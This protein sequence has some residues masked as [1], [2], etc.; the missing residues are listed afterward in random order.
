MTLAEDVLD[1]YELIFE[2]AGYSVI[3]NKAGVDQTL[4]AVK[5]SRQTTLEFADDS[6]VSVMDDD[7]LVL[8]SEFQTAFPDA[9]PERGDRIT[10][11]DHLGTERK[12]DVGLDG[13]ER[14]YDPFGQ[15][16]VGWR[17]HSLEEKV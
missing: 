10:W 4:R 11:T 14:Q 5:G 9:V 8:V 1:H 13:V 2:E 6:A 7:W 16:G 15:F 3:Y 17:I 12:F